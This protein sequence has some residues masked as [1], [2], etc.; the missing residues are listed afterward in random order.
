[1]PEPQPEPV[2]TCEG[3]PA[4]APET[5]EEFDPNPT[6]YETPDAEADPNYRLT[7]DGAWITYT[8]AGE[9]RLNDDGSSDELVMLPVEG[10]VPPDCWAW[11]W[12]AVE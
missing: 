8:Y 4:P 12:R 3:V 7:P 5:Y 2:P 11:Q 10:G 6:R 1:V 9:L